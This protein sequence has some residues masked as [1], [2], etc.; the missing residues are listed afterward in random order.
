MREAHKHLFWFLL[1]VAAVLWG[2]RMRAFE[3]PI[4]HQTRRGLGGPADPPEGAR[5]GASQVPQDA[6]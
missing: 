6:P 2:L 4:P 3:Q 1:A 5:D